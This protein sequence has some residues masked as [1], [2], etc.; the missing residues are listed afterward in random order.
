MAQDADI[1]I[2]RAIQTH[3]SYVSQFERTGMWFG[4]G[5]AEYIDGIGRVYFEAEVKKKIEM[6]MKRCVARIKKV[7]TT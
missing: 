4:V 7:S 2:R 1:E 6:S 3:M 5:G